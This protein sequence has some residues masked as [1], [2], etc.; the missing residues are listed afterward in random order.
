MRLVLVDRLFIWRIIL[1]MVK[2]RS[3]LSMKM[4]FNRPYP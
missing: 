4:F 1:M 2:K 3:F